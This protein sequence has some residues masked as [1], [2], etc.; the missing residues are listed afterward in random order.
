MD[1]ALNFIFLSILKNTLN[2]YFIVAVKFLDFWTPVNFIVNSPNFNVRGSS[3]D[4]C[5]D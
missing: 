4:D 5:S 1:V 2:K 3:R